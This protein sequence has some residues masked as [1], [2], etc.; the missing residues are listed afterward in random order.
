MSGNDNPSTIRHCS[1]R[2]S[3]SNSRMAPVD[4]AGAFALP[5]ARLQ[6][7]PPGLLLV[8][9]RAGSSPGTG[10][11]SSPARLRL[12]HS[13][14]ACQQVP[15]GLLQ[16]RV[17]AHRTQPAP[18]PSSSA[19]IGLEN[20][21]GGELLRGR[22]LTSTAGSV[23][24]A[25][26]GP[27]AAG[28]AGSSPPA[29]WDP[30]APRGLVVALGRGLAEMTPAPGPDPPPGSP[31]TSLATATRSSLSRCAAP[32]AAGTCKPATSPSA[33]RMSKRRARGPPAS[34]NSPWRR[35]AARR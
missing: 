10:V 30:W 24:R 14:T 2:C 8:P 20:P 15:V 19:K 3:S 35:P 32:P 28:G 31:A 5:D 29:G 26:P 34:G 4:V 9:A 23:A 22:K 16:P 18:R 33:V 25:P 11:P 1:S 21:P 13:T 6:L 17:Y 12:A 27:P 7:R